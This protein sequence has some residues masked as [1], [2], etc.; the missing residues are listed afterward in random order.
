MTKNFYGSRSIEEQCDS[1]FIYDYDEKT[2]AKTATIV[3]SR[4]GHAR[5]AVVTIKD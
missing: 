3:K 1:G 4:A 5:E 2:S